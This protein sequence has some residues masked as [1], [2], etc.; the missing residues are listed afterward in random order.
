MVFNPGLKPGLSIELSYQC[1]CSKALN[2]K[3]SSMSLNIAELIILDQI[4]LNLNVNCSLF[5]LL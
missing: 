2:K 1:L 3:L 5:C 4:E